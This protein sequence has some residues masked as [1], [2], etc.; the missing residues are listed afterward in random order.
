MIPPFCLR[1][2]PVSPS[3]VPRPVPEESLL[4]YESVANR[5][6]IKVEP[7]TTGSRRN[8]EHPYGENDD[9]IQSDSFSPI[10]DSKS[11]RC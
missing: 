1:A 6:D 5:L 10:A 8:E 9:T 4:L 3:C 2:R 7:G 11:R